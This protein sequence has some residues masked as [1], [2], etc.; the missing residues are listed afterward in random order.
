MKKTTVV[1]DKWVKENHSAIRE[2]IENNEKQS[3]IYG[4]F[5]DWAENNK[6][7]I[8]STTSFYTLLKSAIKTLKKGKDFKATTPVTHRVSGEEQFNMLEKFVGLIHRGLAI[9]SLIVNGAPGIGKSKTVLDTLDKLNKKNKK[10]VRVY[11]GGVK[12]AYELAKILYQNR[13][14]K[15]IVFD[16]F[17]SAFRTKNQVNLLKTAL[18]DDAESKFISYVDTTKKSKKDKIPECFE[19]NSRIIFIVNKLRI[20]SAIKSRSKI[21]NIELSKDEILERIKQVL[22][23]F[24]PKAPMDL[25]MEVYEFLKKNLNHAKTMDFRKF[26]FAVANLLIDKDERNTT[27]RWKRWTLSELNA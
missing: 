16:D 9:K 11:S 19:F 26:K 1:F 22:S 23:G 6:A 13:K 24:I 17:D 8:M 10:D 18:Q 12:G 7:Q 5:Y 4:Y 21:I 2:F 25:K 20:D 15:I 14:D 27:G 3:R